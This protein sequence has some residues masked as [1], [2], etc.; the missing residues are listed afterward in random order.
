[1]EE[2]KGF[3]MKGSSLY[4][5][6]NLNRGGYKNMPDGRA[7]S[8]ALQMNGDKKKGILTPKSKKRSSEHEAVSVYK[9]TDKYEKI[10]DLEDRIEFIKE[11][12]F[13]NSDKATSEQSKSLA[14]LEKELS[15]IRKTGKN[16]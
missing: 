9:G 16:K 1:M 12:I 7:K 2:N 14:S 6:M 15:M 8:S 5:K 10:A 3:K 4:G 13:N 11:D